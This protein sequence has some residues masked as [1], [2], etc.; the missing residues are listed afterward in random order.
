MRIEAK[1]KISDKPFDVHY[2]LEEGDQVT[3]PDTVGS[4]WV[5]NGWVKNLDT[6]EDN[7]PSKEPVTLDV[8]K[9]Q[10]KPKSTTL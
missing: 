2:A 8:H 7:E 10:L 6:G 5:A 1:T 4:Y 9:A 3:V